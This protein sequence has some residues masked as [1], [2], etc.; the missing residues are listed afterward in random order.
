MPLELLPFVNPYI[1]VCSGSVSVRINSAPST[2]FSGTFCRPKLLKPE[3]FYQLIYGSIFFR[4]GV[5][6][7]KK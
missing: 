6:G 7:T 2:F 5:R 4:S 3:F 1:I